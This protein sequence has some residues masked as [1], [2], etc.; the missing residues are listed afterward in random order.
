[1]PNVS[2]CWRKSTACWG[3]SY[4]THIS[5]TFR[6]LSRVVL[7]EA[8]RYCTLLCCGISRLEESEIPPSGREGLL[9]HEMT[10]SPEESGLDQ[11]L[12]A[13]T[14]SSV[15]AQTSIPSSNNSNPALRLG[16]SVFLFLQ[17]AVATLS[18]PGISAS[19]AEHARRLCWRSVQSLEE[20]LSSST[21]RR[22]NH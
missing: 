3:R 6:L 19:I 2:N 22:L 13:F 10:S 12:S 20:S 18:N 4:L 1:M 21:L 9:K 8:F 11:R 15:P 17:M 7:D 16:V 5:Q 14:F